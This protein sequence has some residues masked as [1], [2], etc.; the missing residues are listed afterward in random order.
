VEKLKEYKIA[1]RGLKDGEH[2]FRY[3]LDKA[4]FDCFEATKG[5]DAQVEATVILVKTPLL[6]KLKISQNGKVKT[7]CDRCLGALD[8]EVSGEME[9]FVKTKER[10]TGNDD[11]Y[12]VLSPTDDH[13]DVSSYVY[14]TYMLSYP[15]RAIHREGECDGEVSEML[16]EY[17]SVEEDIAIDP[18]WDALKKLINN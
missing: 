14:E 1:F 12:I 4:F 18:R 15:I 6:L 2:K 11:D 7:I 17:V 16:N 8:L 5:V 9:L 3:V 10:D 13:L